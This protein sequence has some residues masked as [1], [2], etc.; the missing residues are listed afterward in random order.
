MTIHA[1]LDKTDGYDRTLLSVSVQ[2]STINERETVQ[3]R[4]R[5][6]HVAPGNFK[7]RNEPFGK[8]PSRNAS[9]GSVW[10]LKVDWR[11]LQFQVCELQDVLQFCHKSFFE[12][13]V[14]NAFPM[15][16]TAHD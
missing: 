14:R 16:Q 10:I 2:V 9:F 1:C 5:T 3:K 12:N 15:L 8:L 11:R 4:A 7:L 6:E 13:L